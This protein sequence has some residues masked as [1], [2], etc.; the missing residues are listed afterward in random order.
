MTVSS[1]VREASSAC[2]GVTTVFPVGFQ[3]LDAGDLA[4]TLIDDASEEE[5][6]LVEG[7]DYTLSGDG[8]AGSAEITTLTAYAA[9]K[10]LKRFRTTAR[11]QTADYTPNDGFAAATHERQLDRL[12]LVDQEIDAD[13]A[14][15]DARALR[16][17]EGESMAPLAEQSLRPE[18]VLGF[19]GDGVRT[20]LS[21]TALASRL[22]TPLR[23][24]LG[25][26]FKGDP[27]GNVMA[28][29]PF[30]SLPSLTVP[31]GVDR[32]RTSA[33]G[34]D[35]LG[36][37][38]YVY[39]A[40]VDAAY[41]AAHP[42]IAALTAN[43]RGFRLATDQ[44]FRLEMFGIAADGLA[45]SAAANDAGLLAMVNWFATFEGRKV[46][47]HAPG[48]VT[49]AKSPRL[50][51][52]DEITFLGCHL[53]CVNSDAGIDGLGG[54]YRGAIMLTCYHSSSGAAQ[55][56]MSAAPSYDLAPVAVG[57]RAVTFAIAAEAAA[58]SEGDLIVVVDE[59]FYLKDGTRTRYFKPWAARVA[60]VAVGVVHLDEPAPFAYAGVPKAIAIN[61]GTATHP[62]FLDDDGNPEVLR[63]SRGHEFVNCTIE[64]AETN[65]VDGAALT[66]AA[67]GLF[68]PG[69]CYRLRVV[70]CTLRGNGSPTVGNMFWH[71]EFSG[72]TIYGNRYVDFGFASFRP[73]ARDNRYFH[74]H[75]PSADLSAAL[76]SLVY[77][78][79]GSVL[80][81]LE[82][83]LVFMEGWDGTHLFN[84][85]GGAIGWVVKGDRYYLSDA[86]EA[87]SGSLLFIQDQDAD[88]YS[89]GF[90]LSDVEVRGAAEFE[91]M[92]NFA[93]NAAHAARDRRTR[94]DIEAPQVV[95]PGT[96]ANFILMQQLKGVTLRAE[97]GDHVVNTF[98]V[99]S[100]TSSRFDIQAKNL[101]VSGPVDATVVIVDDG[102][103][104]HVPGR[105]IKAGG[106]V[107]DRLNLTSIASAASTTVRTLAQIEAYGQD[108]SFLFTIQAPASGT[109]PIFGTARLFVP[110]GGAVPSIQ[111]TVTGGTLTV[112]GAGDLIFTN[113]SGA[114]SGNLFVDVKP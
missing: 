81:R 78:N 59:K 111:S 39:D 102:T 3:Y 84:I 20:L 107:I 83:N 11:A 56:D 75:P 31:V 64:Q 92:V 88:I 72:N 41:V 97:L 13:L 103:Y 89:E 40:A 29:G 27:G 49:W 12:T 79:E 60:R 112:N 48:I 73:V 91:R 50:W 14:D 71:A 114:A 106:F 21:S 53:T 45:S 33:Y 63:V 6:V 74:Y 46:V 98:S 110:G 4:V 24:L 9:G 104:R 26:A 1:T 35:G 85:A 95:D 58:F 70:N 96:A 30:A 28:V 77:A 52:C 66:V 16:L 62:T 17:P 10:T 54:G 44:V 68:Q 99:A 94:I 82:N 18:T 57:D 7:V 86:K 69:G 100:S 25:A 47:T 32:V 93:G 80:A 19:D 42:K 108:R 61:S 55:P 38:D 51:R 22:L 8:V 34:L 23:D 113:T 65:E 109:L 15:L 101:T 105:T 76:F 36:A 5:T 67:H 87:H 37:G 43:G 90:E 2:N